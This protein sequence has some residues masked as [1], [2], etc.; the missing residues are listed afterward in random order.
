MSDVII[1]TNVVVVANHQNLKV[2]PDCVA[3]C[4][5]FLI[6]ARNNHVVLLDDGA[7]MRMRC[8]WG[9]PINLARSS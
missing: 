8:G 4:I 6:E 2:M 5:Q 7:N 9:D 1:D 3:A